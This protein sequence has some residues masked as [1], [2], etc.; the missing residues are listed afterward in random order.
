MGW[1]LVMQ[2]SFVMQLVQMRGE[3]QYNVM[4]LVLM[5]SNLCRWGSGVKLSTILNLCRWGRT[6][7]NEG[8]N[9]VQIFIYYATCAND[10]ELV[11][12]MGGTQYNVHLFCNL[13]RWGVEHVV[14]FYL[15]CNLCRWGVVE[16][17]VQCSFVM[18]LVQMRLIH[19][20]TQGAMSNHHG[21]QAFQAN[22]LRLSRSGRVW[23]G[24]SRRPRPSMPI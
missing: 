24:S 8:W 18:Q 10:I 12:T 23:V 7:A 11:Q 9:S 2:R 5:T 3:T 17:A 1:N 6:C 20:V 22:G 15:L 21:N 14:Q 19:A 13:C 16:H 4:Q